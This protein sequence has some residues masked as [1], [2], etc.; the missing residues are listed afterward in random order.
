MNFLA[1][2]LLAFMA[3]GPFGARATPD[4]EIADTPCIWE[5]CGSIPCETTVVDTQN[6]DLN[7]PGMS[8]MKLFIRTHT[9]R[10]IGMKTA[11]LA[12]EAAIEYPK[13]ILANCLRRHP[14]VTL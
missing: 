10:K 14:L 12:R 5:P 2:I 9:E 13:Y 4:P 8:A 6:C 3:V 7:G 11:L 1:T